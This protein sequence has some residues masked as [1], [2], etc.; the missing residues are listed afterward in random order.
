[1]IANIENLLEGGVELDDEIDGDEHIDQIEVN[2]QVD[3]VP[4]I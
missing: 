3:E 2:I 1:M 4:L